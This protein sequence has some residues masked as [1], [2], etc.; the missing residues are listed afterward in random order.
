MNE[1]VERAPQ[2]VA[3]AAN[4]LPAPADPMQLLSIAV[5]QGAD[6]EK[7]E[8]LMDLQERWE[9]GNARK[10]FDAAISD[11]KAEIRPIVKSGEVGY[12]GKDGNFIGYQ[13]ETLDG[14]ASQIDP[15]LS[16]HGLSYRFRSKQEGGMVHITCVVSHREG[17]S[18]E[19]TLCG[20]PDES[21][22]K[23]GYQAIGSAATYLQ[24]YT[25]KL[26]LGLSATKD[27]DGQGA[28]LGSTPQERLTPEQL[29]GLKRALDDSGVEVERF[30]KAANV[31]RIEDVEA[32]RLNGALSWINNV[33]QQKTQQ[34][35]SAAGIFGGAQ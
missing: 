29:E 20:P 30:L 17:H 9:A 21:G 5:S 19:T 22:K 15:V 28:N 10:A 11:A 1:V 6:I 12:K 26:A 31:Q 35:P 16:E 34:Q 2:Q 4:T 18:E 14:I 33:S 3:A 25:L 32:R 7:L 13:H 8:K 27:D 23:N 24:R